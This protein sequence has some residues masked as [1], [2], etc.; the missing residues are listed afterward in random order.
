MLLHAYNYIP[1]IKHIIFFYFLNIVRINQ[2]TLLQNSRLIAVDRYYVKI[3][4]C[5]SFP[6]KKRLFSCFQIVII[7]IITIVFVSNYHDWIYVIHS[8]YMQ[9][10]REQSSQYFNYFF[11]ILMNLTIFFSFEIQS[12][13]GKLSITINFFFLLII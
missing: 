5:L 13:E 8:L 12:F 2:T 1:C 10:P 11:I 9:G 3:L 4:I 7:I 6:P